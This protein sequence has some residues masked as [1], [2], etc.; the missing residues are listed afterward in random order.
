MARGAVTKASEREVQLKRSGAA[1]GDTLEVTTSR[2]LY[3]GILMPHHDFSAEDTVT[4]KLDSGYNVG[5]RLD[6]SARIAV[7]EKAPQRRAAGRK[8][9]RPEGRPKVSILGTGGTIASYVDYRTGAVQPAT[10]PEE[11]AF[12][13]PEM[14]AIAD[15]TARVVYQVFSED[16]TPRHWSELAME[17]KRE[18]DGGA[19]GVVIPHGTDTLGYT[20][21]ALSF[22]LSDLPGPV[23]VVGA[24]RSS[25]R[26]SSDAAT[27]LLSA[28]R[29]AAEADLG[30]VV[31]VMHSSMGDGSSE[32][33]RGTR[34]RKTHTSRRDTFQSINA[35]P[36]GRVDAEGVH[37]TSLVRGRGKGP[38]K[39]RAEVE[40]GVKIIY[41][42]PGL[43]GDD[44]ASVGR[45]VVLA[46]TGLGHVPQR[47]VPE[48]ARLTKAG[49]LVVMA[50]QCIR[51]RVNMNVYSTGR[52]LLKAG[53]VSARDMTPE[54]AL[55]KLMWA[56]GQAQDA[57][58]AAKTFGENVAGEIEERSPLDT[59]A[60]PE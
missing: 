22:M 28:V 14:F 35:P 36:I 30:E 12:A 48:V 17:V 6:S 18:F 4:L 10:T 23:V 7:V 60:A 47:L 24:Q 41:S 13:V 9:P 42:Y 16:L 53:A 15:V 38:V 45:G 44:F 33:I 26:P 52:D 3:R 40:E 50:S 55:V 54:T 51:G 56:L 59:E 49:K 39:L 34:A 27:N 5:V 19:L 25:D 2:G 8:L 20:A 57:R 58:E 29:V 11:L 43:R 21:A 1:A 31:V 32:M 37:V 46:G